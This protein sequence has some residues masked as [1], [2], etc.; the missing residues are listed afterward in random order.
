M[1]AYQQ[2]IRHHMDQLAMAHP[3]NRFTETIQPER[4]DEDPAKLFDMLDEA[5]QQPSLQTAVLNA[6]AEQLG[7]VGKSAMADLAPQVGNAAVAAAS[8]RWANCW[9]KSGTSSAT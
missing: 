2:R 1:V 8:S 7:A 9:Q 3:S 4:E 6:V 5:E